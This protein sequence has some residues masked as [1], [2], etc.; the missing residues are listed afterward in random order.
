[1][2]RLPYQFSSEYL[3][4]QVKR[5]EK[6]KPAHKTLSEIYNRQTNEKP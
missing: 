4:I 6:V 3:K 1:M 5:I 2:Q